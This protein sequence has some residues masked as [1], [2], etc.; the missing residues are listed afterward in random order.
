[1]QSMADDSQSIS[2]RHFLMGSA[3]LAAACALPIP[4]WARGANLIGAGKGF[5]TLSGEDIRLTIGNSHFVTGGRAGHAV[6]VNGTVPGPLLRLKQGQTVRLHV[7][8]NLAEDSSV[9]WH[10]LLV[11]FQFDGVPGVSF[12]GIRPGET[13]TYEI[14][15]RQAGTY[16]WHSHSG[17]QEQ[18][19]HYGPLVIDPAVPDR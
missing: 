3:V 10:G 8:N 7:T 2:R 18:Q 5:G 15:I 9:H 11:P 1:M 6:T 16:W 19:G 17:L 13:F 12:P 4:A 14:P